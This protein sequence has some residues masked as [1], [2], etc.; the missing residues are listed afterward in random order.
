[1]LCVP[2]GRLQAEHMHVVR[3]AVEFIKGKRKASQKAMVAKR[4][5]SRLCLKLF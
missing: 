4:K 1:M 3:E 2:H 5:K